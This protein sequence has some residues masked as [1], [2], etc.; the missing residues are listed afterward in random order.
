MKSPKREP[1]C[2]CLFPLKDQTRPYDETK[3]Q[4]QQIPPGAT[5]KP[6][7]YNPSFNYKPELEEARNAF[8]VAEVGRHDKDQ[9]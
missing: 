6:R 8:A 3:I 1:F 7:R 2:V 5:S 4:I 9:D